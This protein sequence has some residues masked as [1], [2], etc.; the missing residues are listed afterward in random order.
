MNTAMKANVIPLHKCPIE[1]Y[2]GGTHIGIEAPAMELFQAVVRAIGGRGEEG[3]EGTLA[4]RRK[5]LAA[6][7]VNRRGEKEG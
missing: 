6:I 2:I 4:H 5:V 3:W 7:A 1:A